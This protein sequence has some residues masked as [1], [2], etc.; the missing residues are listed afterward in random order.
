[1]KEGGRGAD[2]VN[3]ERGKG[4]KKKTVNQHKSQFGLCPYKK[5]KCMLIRVFEI[6]GSSSIKKK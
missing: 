4:I 5:L 1:M 2:K 3:K 6:K